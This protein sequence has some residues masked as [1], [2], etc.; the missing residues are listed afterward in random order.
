MINLGLAFEKIKSKVSA[1]IPEETKSLSSRASKQSRLSSARESS[2][3]SS[4]QNLTTQPG[5]LGLP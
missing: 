2:G 3:L 1:L 4:N 5:F